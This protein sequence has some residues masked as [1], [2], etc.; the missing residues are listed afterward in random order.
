MICKANL[1][2]GK[3]FKFERIYF[4][5]MILY[6]CHG[7]VFKKITRWVMSHRM[8]KKLTIIALNRAIN[9]Q[10]PRNDSSIILIAAVNTQQQIN[11][12]IK[13]N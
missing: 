9:Q 1:I 6:C 4:V 12:M 3:G 7:S 5:T 2:P 13:T 11:I 8:T 10:P